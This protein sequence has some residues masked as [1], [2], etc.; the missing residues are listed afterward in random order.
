MTYRKNINETLTNKH[1]VFQSC[2]RSA[3]L[4]RAAVVVVIVVVALVHLLSLLL[5]PIVDPA[6]PRCDPSPTHLLS[7]LL[8]PIV[9]PRSPR[10]LLL[11]GARDRTAVPL[12]AVVTAP[13]LLG[14]DLLGADGVGNGGVAVISG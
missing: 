11:L 5:V 1:K 14:A 4:R 8:V 6:L 3:S 12:E 13:D 10:R 9:D 2:G 7:L